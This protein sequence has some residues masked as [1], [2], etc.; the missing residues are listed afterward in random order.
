MAFPLQNRGGQMN[1]KSRISL[2]G[3]ERGYTLIEALVVV[4][5][6]G[7]FSLIAIPNFLGMYRSSKLKT[8]L[9]NVTTD[10][11]WARQRAVSRDRF[12]M[13]SVMG[14]SQWEV[15]EGTRDAKDPTK[16]NWEPTP[17]KGPTELDS[18]V[19]FTST[20]GFKDV[21]GDGHVD[22]VFGGDGTVWNMP[23]PISDAYIKVK[24]EFPLPKNEY[25]IS[26][27][28]AGRVAAN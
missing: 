10:M 1:T 8:S 6:I 7:I 20:G 23:D 12:A 4:A 11:R 5:I 17:V 9:R 25:T 15:F 27:S 16:I 24:T 21:D 22:I 19:Q 3:A 2:S 28:N 26:L 14:T 13:F 18:S